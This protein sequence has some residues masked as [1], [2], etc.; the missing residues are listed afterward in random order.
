MLKF[1]IYI[2]F[3]VACAGLVRVFYSNLQNYDKSVSLPSKLTKKSVRHIW[4][5]ICKHNR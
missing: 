3:M 1:L 5:V 4:H 2:V